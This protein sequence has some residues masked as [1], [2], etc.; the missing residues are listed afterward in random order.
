V[1]IQR[2]AG[3][4]AEATGRTIEEVLQAETAAAMEEQRTIEALQ[5]DRRGRG[6]L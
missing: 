1:K 2:L 3:Q 6:R 5:G 4:V